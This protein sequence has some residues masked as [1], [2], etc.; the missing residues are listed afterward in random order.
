MHTRMADRAFVKIISI[1]RLNR[2][3]QLH[4]KDPPSS[5]VS[6]GRSLCCSPG[7]QGYILIGLVY[8]TENARLP[9]LNTTL[10]Q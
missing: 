1:K 10:L 5:L 8:M 4:F 2:D 9:A 7:T 6:F 3:P